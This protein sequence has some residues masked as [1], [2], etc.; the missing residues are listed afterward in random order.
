M[1]RWELKINKGRWGTSTSTHCRAAACI[2]RRARLCSAAG[3]RRLCTQLVERLTW[4]FPAPPLLLELELELELLAC[5]SGGGVA[6]GL[7][8]EGGGE[9]GGGELST[10]LPV[11]AG[12]EA[13]LKVAA[14]GL[15]VLSGVLNGVVEVEGLLLPSGVP[16]SGGEAVPAG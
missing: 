7:L 16:D 15:E 11:V 8:G 12:V 9:L 1:A 4:P 14:E 10:G 5:V 3:Q 2:K 6:G 13:A